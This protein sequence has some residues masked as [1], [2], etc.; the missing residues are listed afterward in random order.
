MFSE[1][2]DGGKAT[3]FRC[4]SQWDHG[5]STGIL[6]CCCIVAGASHFRN[7]VKT[8]NPEYDYSVKYKLQSP[9]GLGS[10]DKDNTEN[11]ATYPTYIYPCSLTTNTHND[12]DQLALELFGPIALLPP[13][14]HQAHE[15]VNLKKDHWKSALLKL[16]EL[17]FGDWSF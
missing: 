6:G 11:D 14:H 9:N 15:P 4:H 16:I 5:L 1:M 8:R 3:P 10:Q 17:E 7:H 12:N 2:G 13:Y